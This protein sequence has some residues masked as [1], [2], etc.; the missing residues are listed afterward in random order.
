MLFFW[1]SSSPPGADGDRTVINLHLN[2]NA[3]ARPRQIVDFDLPNDAKVSAEPGAARDGRV[4]GITIHA[5]RSADRPGAYTPLRL[6]NGEGETD[7]PA[8]C[9]SKGL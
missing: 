8:F 1:E 5:T 7:V 4:G 9:D 2:R 3:P 6:D